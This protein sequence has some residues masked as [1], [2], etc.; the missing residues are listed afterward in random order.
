MRAIVL[1]AIFLAGSAL[2]SPALY[3]GAVKVRA[4]E[5]NG[6]F[7]RVQAMLPLDAEILSV[8]RE[9]EVVVIHFAFDPEA[10][11]VWRR[12]IMTR[13]VEPVP[14]PLDRFLMERGGVYFWDE[15][16]FAQPLGK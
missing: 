5:W 8:S 4:T 9:R 13:G 11:D 10:P 7:S 2:A 14:V 12:V 1:A 3:T 15:G 16:Q 6:G